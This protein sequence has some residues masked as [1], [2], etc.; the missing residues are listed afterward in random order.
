MI[1][2]L[3]SIMMSVGVLAY[4]IL[5]LAAMLEYVIPPM[6][7]DSIVLLGG[8]YAVRGQQPWP[9]VFLVVVM[10]SVTGAAIN[11]VFGRYLRRRMDARPNDRPLFG[12]TH[13]RLM[14][15]QV[16][17]WHWGAWLLLFNRFM[18]G[19]RS[20][21][22]VAAGASR[23]PPTRTLVL[24]A[25]SAVLHTA[26]VMALGAAVG[27][28]LERL[29]FWVTRYQWGAMAL[30]GVVALALLVRFL[31]KRRQPEAT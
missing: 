12:I 7:G 25:V 17:V 26:A 30:F 3:D 10:G 11:Y 31:V 24:G 1:E 16:K 18:P 23:L 29:A 22:F 28:N 27:G 14:K 19:I 21:V 2:S 9:L 6:P 5:F 20:L 15:V 13:E 8:V 4:V